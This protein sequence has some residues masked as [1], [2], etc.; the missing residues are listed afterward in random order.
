MAVRHG[1]TGSDAT[2]MVRDALVST[3]RPCMSM[4]VAV[5]NASSAAI[6]NVDDTGFGDTASDVADDSSSSTLVVPSITTTVAAIGIPVG[7]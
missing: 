4:I 7:V 6:V 3:V 5:V 2:L 1:P